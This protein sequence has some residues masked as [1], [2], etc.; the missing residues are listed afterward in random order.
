M[1]PSRP[2]GTGLPEREPTDRGLLVHHASLPA[3]CPPSSVTDCEP[4]AIGTATAYRL[5]NKKKVRNFINAEITSQGYFKCYVENVPKD[6]TGCPGWWIFRVAWDY[7]VND[8]QVTIKGVRGDWT[9]GDNLDTVNALTAGNTM[10]LE[11]AAK[12]TWTYQQAK[13]RNFTTYQF[14]DSDGSPG[15]YTEVQV[16]FLP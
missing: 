12:Q 14:L 7:F 5:E 8:Q 15:K 3:P 9:F 2:P 6:N 16:V 4:E 10:T 13:A 11:E 1:L